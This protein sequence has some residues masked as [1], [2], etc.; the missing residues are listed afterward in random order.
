MNTSELLDQYLAETPSRREGGALPD[1]SK[2][3]K[4]KKRQ[5]IDLIEAVLKRYAYLREHDAE[6]PKLMEDLQNMA[7]FNPMMKQVSDTMKF[8]TSTDAVVDHDENLMIVPGEKHFYRVFLTT[9]KIER[10][11]D[12]VELELNWEIIPDHVRLMFDAKTDLRER[13]HSLSGFLMHDSV[14]GKYF[15]VKQG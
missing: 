15:R 14:Y 10:V 6:I 8:W 5:I 13:C 4:L 2:W 7:A 1:L 12:N 3:K 11:T 9:G